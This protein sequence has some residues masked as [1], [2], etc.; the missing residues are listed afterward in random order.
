LKKS[1]ELLHRYFSPA[2]AACM[3]LTL[4]STKHP[5][6]LYVLFSTEMAER[7]SFYGMRA[8]L[9]YYMTK[10]ILL[11]ATA[12]T[13]LGYPEIK[14]VLKWLFGP[15]S[16]QA[17]SSQLYGLYTG[18]LYFTPFFG[19]I[20]A[21]RWLG[22]RKTVI[23]GGVLMAV[24]EFMLMQESL[25]FP[26]LLLLILGNG[27]FKPNISTQVGNL[28]EPGDHRRD[29]AFSIFYV[30][31]NL[32]AIFSPLIAGTLGEKCGWRWGF[33]AAGIGMIIS[34]AI[35]LFGQPHLAP[36][37]V[38]KRK[39]AG[40]TKPAGPLLP[41]D[42][43]KIGALVVLCTLNIVFWGVYEQQG[44]T[45][46]LWVDSC[47]DRGI[48]GWEMPATWFQT[49]NPCM[50]VLLTPL[51]LV[52]W[53]RQE[54][55]KKEPSSIAKMAIG[56][57]LLG[58]SFLVLLP[59]AHAVTQGGKASLLSLF[60]CTAVL[61]VGELY[62]SPVGL[63]LVTKL[64]PPRMVS[65]LMGMWF[66]SSFFG[67]YLCGFMGS[68]WEKMSHVNYFMMLSGLACFAGLCMVALLKPLKRAIGHGH[69]EK[70][71]V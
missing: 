7:F 61:T 46:A 54:K 18:F 58:I 23:L 29:R 30:G 59:Q 1:N 10:S 42:W 16:I 56:C 24:A 19:G 38:G 12:S 5:P 53:R 67:N 48:F 69:D 3:R 17:M 37:F 33:C 51:V 28:Y 35:Y 66:L 44:N 26:A 4:P 64:S 55:R 31:I 32:G 14:H 62:L 45:L 8:I 40:E 41:D 50:I 22:Q 27:C 21:D 49:F 9:V 63:S 34:L 47:T 39:Q 70:V 43:K 68:F 57:F 13:I 52:F 20:L 15:L 71:N 36:D 11:P 60:T 65:M 25:F 6:G 2:K